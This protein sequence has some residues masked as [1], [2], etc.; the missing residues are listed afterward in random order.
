MH[1]DRKSALLIVTILMVSCLLLGCL[2]AVGVRT[3]T[4]HT[5][6]LPDE[7]FFCE[8]ADGLHTPEHIYGICGQTEQKLPAVSGFTGNGKN[9][10]TKRTSVSMLLLLLS[11]SLLF[12]LFRRR[13]FY[14]YEYLHVFFF[15]EFL[16]ELYICQAKD[17]KKR[18]SVCVIMEY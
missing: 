4:L 13:E 1:R 7:R 11:V 3:S 10:L 12:L 8:S 6:C 5:D 2:S 16:R 9:F 14:T 17:G 15:L 18:Q